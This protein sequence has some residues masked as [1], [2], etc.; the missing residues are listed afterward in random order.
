MAP[1]QS[2]TIPSEHPTGNK[3]CNGFTR[4]HDPQG[5]YHGVTVLSRYDAPTLAHRVGVKLDCI[6]ILRGIEQLVT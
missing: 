4:P 1:C 5:S 3:A 2:L 6:R